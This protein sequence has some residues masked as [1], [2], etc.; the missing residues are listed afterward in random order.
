MFISYAHEDELLCK[1]LEK[2]LTLLKRQGFI[3]TWH[4]RNISAGTEWAHEIDTHLKTADII[5]LLVSADFLASDYCYSVEMRQAMERYERGE[6]HVIPVVLR[7]V[8]WQD[9]PFGKLQAL[10]TDA[11]PVKGPG[12]YNQDEAFLNIIEGIK[13]IVFGE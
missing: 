2:H 3:T 1:D 13:K 7:P 8:Y 9:A 11:R 4:D 10:P 5:L 12:W 6:A